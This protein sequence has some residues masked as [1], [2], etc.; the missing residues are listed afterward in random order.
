MKPTLIDFPV[1]DHCPGEIR[2]ARISLYM[3]ILGMLIILSATIGCSRND[4]P[5]TASSIKSEPVLRKFKG[6]VRHENKPVT[7][8]I[9]RVQLTEDKTT[10]ED[11]GSFALLHKTT[12]ESLTV[13]AWAKGYYV[14]WARTDSGG[15]QVEIDLNPY[16]T[17]DNPEY[18]WFSHEGASGSESCSH[19]MPSFDEWQADAHSRSA[20]NPRFLTMYN[21]TDVY[22]SQSPP[23]SYGYNR[24]YGR[25]PLRPDLTKPYFGPGY[26]L[27]FPGTAGNC[28]ACH[29]PGAAAAPG[30][31][32]AADPNQASGVD[33]EG[34]FCEF[35][36]K[37]G[38]V[39]LNPST[40]LPNSNMAG[41]LSMRLYRPAANQQLFFGNF[42]DVT[43]RVS[44]LPLIEE[45]A[46]CA[47]CHY[48][49]FWGVVIYNSFGE[50]LE[51]PY[52]DPKSGKTCQNCHMPPVNYDY[53]V[54]P[55]KGGFP[56]DR[57]KI[58]SHKM[59]GAEDE[60]LLQ[61]ALTMTVSTQYGIG[62][63]DVRVE[64]YNDKTG[65]HIPTDSPL[66][67]MILLVEAADELGRAFSLT[68]GPT[69]PD[70]GGIGEPEKGYYAGLPGKAFAKVLMELW[71]ELSPSGAYWNPT[72]IVS[73]N[74]IPAFGR[75][76]SM[77]T[78]AVP[79][80][81]R[82]SV[83][84]RLVFRRAFKELMDQK[85]WDAPDIIMAERTLMVNCTMRER[86][87]RTALR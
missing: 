34:V 69:V 17:T 20:V 80:E 60:Q 30:K 46:F 23:T 57:R 22:G 3:G 5:P 58:F 54:Y 63:L 15:G 16:Y 56:R 14:G 78:F 47:P 70:W 43:R 62:A 65:H 87:A 50:W 72:R 10:T 24:D 81:A 66:R 32:Y 82:A 51:S 28:S 83:S 76:V 7:G 26:K 11:D 59:P 21:G 27:D 74:R 68:K 48:G 39:T 64:L 44:Y 1:T 61:N 29:V 49:D 18:D 84:V 55:E 86:I 53:F 77:Y 71:T 2:F 41:V 35:C 13:T 31:A 9:V 67:H 6:F 36:H 25:F 42:D 45:S 75:D 73:D 4:S 85:G 52:S 33:K 37:I 40:G 8:A 38:D 79:G 19:C 12:A